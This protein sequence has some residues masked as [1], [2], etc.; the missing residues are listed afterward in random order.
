MTNGIKIREEVA[1]DKRRGVLNA[2]SQA[3]SKDIAHY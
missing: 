1:T 3:T 2:I